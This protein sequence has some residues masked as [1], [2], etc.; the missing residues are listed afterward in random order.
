MLAELD[1]AQSMRARVETVLM[2]LL[3][4]GDVSI[5]TVGRNMGLSRQTL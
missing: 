4:M 3:E 5:E 2:P 1:R